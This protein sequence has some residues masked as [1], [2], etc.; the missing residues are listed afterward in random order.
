MSMLDRRAFIRN[1]TG[2]AAAPHAAGKRDQ[3]DCEGISAPPAPATATLPGPSTP[4]TTCRPAGLRRLRTEL[5]PRCIGEGQWYLRDV[6][7]PFLKRNH[8]AIYLSRPSR[9]RGFPYLRGTVRDEQVPDVLERARYC[10][11]VFGVLEE[12]KA[13]PALAWR[14]PRKR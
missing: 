6:P 10:P 7:C 8:C 13:H 2:L 5:T 1:A 11:V 12:L 9:C 4:S 14:R 3:D